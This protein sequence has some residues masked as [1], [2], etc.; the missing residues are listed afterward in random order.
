MHIP[1]NAL[2][3]MNK[4]VSRKSEITAKVAKIK[5][6]LYKFIVVP[7]LPSYKVVF[8]MYRLNLEEHLEIEET[9]IYFGKGESKEAKFF[10]TD[11]LQNLLKFDMMFDEVHLKKGNKIVRSEFYDT[12]EDL[13]VYDH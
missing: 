11:T 7:F 12:V 13:Q 10:F 1:N 6:D 8:V 5:K 3:I 2:F 4:L 9:I